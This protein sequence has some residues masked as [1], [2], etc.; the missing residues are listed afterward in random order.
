MTVHEAAALDLP[1]LNLLIIVS[2]IRSFLLL[3]LADL[4]LSIMALSGPSHV[5]HSVSRCQ[6]YLHTVDHHCMRNY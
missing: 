6:T 5:S 3:S 2:S 4:K 1:D